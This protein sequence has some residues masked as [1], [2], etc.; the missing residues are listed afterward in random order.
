[1]NFHVHHEG[2]FHYIEEGEGEV[3]LLLHG[4]FGALSNF[5]DLVNYFKQDYKVV[6]PMLPIYEL[7]LLKVNLANLTHHIED[8]VNYKNYNTINALGNSLGGHI[9]LLYTLQNMHK[10]H[11]L[12]L[13]GSSGLYENTMGDSFPKRGNY[14]FIKQK[15]EYTFYK[16][17]TATKELVDEVYSI[18][19]NREK[20]LRVV[21]VA[22]SAIR[23]N[24]GN[25]LPKI[26]V[27]ALLIWGKQDRITPPEVANE[28]AGLI[29]NSELYFIDECGH[30]PMMEQPAQFNRILEQFLIKNA[31]NTINLTI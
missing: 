8:F 16:P 13:T 24:M 3:L 9:A 7:P 1:M 11:T 30:A 20:A 26:N 4:L 21:S 27:P 22:K 23:N 6:I 17:E 31:V 2:K 12:I 14:E 18:V 25:H 5:T 29:P 10:V 28:F 19:T 15:T